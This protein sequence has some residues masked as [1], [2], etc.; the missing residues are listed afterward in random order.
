MR[1]QILR[2]SESVSMSTGGQGP[3]LTH[4]HAP[5]LC[6]AEAR[7]TSRLDRVLMRGPV[8]AHAA[9]LTGHEPRGRTPAGLWP[10]DH[11]GVVVQVEVD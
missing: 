11:A 9:R 5:D 8:V 10:S 6:N 7:F 3:G 4:G 2:V 1:H